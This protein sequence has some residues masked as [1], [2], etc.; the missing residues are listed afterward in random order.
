MIS[1]SKQSKEEC[2]NNLN[3]WCYQLA[4]FQV[5]THDWYPKIYYLDVARS[6][7]FL[8]FSQPLQAKVYHVP[9]EKER[10]DIN[11]TK[12]KWQIASAN[13]VPSLCRNFDS[14]NFKRLTLVW[15]NWYMVFWYL[16]LQVA[17]YF[18]F[19]SGHNYLPVFLYFLY[20]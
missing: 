4:K 12:W 3:C 1:W 15:T 9:K 14:V 20:L 2:M 17:K 8:T 7:S 6:I 5:S 11:E 18:F 19:I 10:E 13:A 16:F